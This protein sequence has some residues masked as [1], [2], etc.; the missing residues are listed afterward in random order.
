MLRKAREFNMITLRNHALRSYMTWLHMT[1]SVLD[2]VFYNSR[3]D[4]VTGAD[5][6]N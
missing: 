6:E 3:L 5:F 2:T 4:N 1:L